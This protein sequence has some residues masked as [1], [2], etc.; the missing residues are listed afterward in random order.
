MMDF[1]CTVYPIHTVVQTAKL[2]IET[3]T[4][5]T[6]LDKIRKK[7]YRKRIAHEKIL[8]GVKNFR[9]QAILYI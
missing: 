8:V 7:K 5:M 4:D 6:L 3:C 2:D 1:V 9:F